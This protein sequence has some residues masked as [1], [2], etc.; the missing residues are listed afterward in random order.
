MK[1]SIIA[2]GPTSRLVD[3]GRDPVDVL[4]FDIP[5]WGGGSAGGLGLTDAIF[6]A[7]F[8]GWA[9]RFGLRRRATLAGMTIG[10]LGA[11]VLSL[12]TD[13]AIPALPL[14]A[15]GYLLPNVDRLV[16]AGPA[17]L[18]TPRPRARRRPAGRGCRSAAPRWRRSARP[19]AAAPRRRSR[20]GSCRPAISHA[21]MSPAM[22]RTGQHDRRRRRHEA[23]D[24]R[25]PA[26][27]LAHRLEGH[28]VRR[29]QDDLDRRRDVLDL[30]LA[31]DERAG[32]REHRGVE[33]VAEQ[34]E[35]RGR[36]RAR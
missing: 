26:L 33:R 25:E 32:D 13:E 21:G 18:G 30:L 15:A 16:R 24:L 6:L 23:Q 14:V 28:E 17:G 12:A 36:R 20:A 31:R 35:Q 5:A 27:R 4:S 7:M 11:L 3:A 1:N 2:S 19:R 34:E 22:T 8:A 9:W 10:L 29:E